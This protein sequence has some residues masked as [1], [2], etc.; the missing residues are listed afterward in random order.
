MHA[1]D[2]LNLRILHMFESNFSLDVVHIKKK[3]KKKEKKVTEFSC[4]LHKCPHTIIYLS[5]PN[6]L[7]KVLLRGRHWV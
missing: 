2:D 6:P 1:Q 3:K 4:L 7:V 5:S